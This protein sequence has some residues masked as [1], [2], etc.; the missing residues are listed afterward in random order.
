MEGALSS[1]GGW[2]PPLFL[3]W[4]PGLGGPPF[5]CPGLR[6]CLDQC[7]PC[8]GQFSSLA[9]APLQLLISQSCSRHLFRPGTPDLQPMKPWVVFGTGGDG[10]TWKGKAGVNH[11]GPHNETCVHRGFR[12]RMG[13]LVWRSQEEP[14]S[15][16]RARDPGNRSESPETNPHVCGQLIHDKG[17]KTI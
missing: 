7:M 3:G 2:R 11:R 6:L 15:W 13:G 1:R 4:A 12:I 9:Y 10:S 8:L 14:W 16:H 17:G 5:L